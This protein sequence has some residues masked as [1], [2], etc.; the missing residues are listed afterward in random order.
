MSASSLVSAAVLAASTPVADDSCRPPV[1]FANPP[2]PVVA[3]MGRLVSRTERATLEGTLEEVIRQAEATPLSDTVSTEGGLPG[4]RGDFL[5]TPGAFD[6]PGARRLV[7]LTD[8]STLSEQILT[9]ERTPARRDFTYVVWNYSTARARPVRYGVG[10]FV[11]TQRAD[12]RTDV[13]WTYGFALR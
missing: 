12:G 11:H 13:A 10:R 7:C 4:V 3:P 6:R 9:L 5:L 2:P 1:G 8:G